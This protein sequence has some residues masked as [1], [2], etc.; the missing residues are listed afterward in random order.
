MGR[1]RG[2]RCPW[3]LRPRLRHAQ[4]P[5]PP[6]RVCDERDQARIERLGAK[7]EVPK[8]RAQIRSVDQLEGEVVG[9]ARNAEVEHARDVPVVEQRRQAR[10]AQEHVDELR[11]SCE[12][13]Q[14]ALEA[15]ALLEAAGATSHGDE[16][17]GHPADAEPFYELVV[18]K[19][20]RERSGHRTVKLPH[21]SARDAPPHE[22]VVPFHACA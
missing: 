12:R 5:M 10:L 19:G 3:F 16:G 7:A 4:S 6:Q 9:I 15:N 8:H 21:T 18:A 11:V 20:F 22:A 13:R 17:L 2:G 1:R 14:D